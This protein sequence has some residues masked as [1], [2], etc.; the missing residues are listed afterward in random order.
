VVPSRNPRPAGAPNAPIGPMSSGT[1]GGGYPYDDQG[2]DQ[3]LN[4]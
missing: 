3:D 1:M 2:D 4:Y